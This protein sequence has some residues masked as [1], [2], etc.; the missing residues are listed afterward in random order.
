MA[1]L[2]KKE[3]Q[4]EIEAIGVSIEAHESQMKLHIYAIKVDAYLKELMVKELEK[5]K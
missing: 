5:F 3:L 1:L 2:T 4:K